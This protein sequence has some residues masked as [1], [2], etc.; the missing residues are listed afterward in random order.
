VFF[1]YVLFQP[2]K[3][4]VKS[5]DR[6]QSRFAVANIWAAGEQLRWFFGSNHKDDQIL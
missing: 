3:G 1:A 2:Y 5:H 6:G 4:A